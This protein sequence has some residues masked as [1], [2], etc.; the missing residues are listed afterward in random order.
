MTF[1]ILSIVV[2]NLIAIKMP[3][4][5]TKSEMYCTSLF[6]GV[7][8]LIT[9]TVL[10]LKFNVYGYFQKG[11]DLKTFLVIFGVYPAVNIIFLNYFPFGKNAKS[12][13]L[14]ILAWSLFITLFEWASIKAGY[15]YHNQWKL[16]YS[17]LLYHAILSIL[18][19][20]LTYFRR[21]NS[22]H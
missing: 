15:F 16:W 8:Q 2:F 5:L 20:N 1:L 21:L 11:V 10:D 18:V 14:Y 17:Y 19:W 13:I 7:F 22:K 3:K 12:K 6:S 9:D 4:R